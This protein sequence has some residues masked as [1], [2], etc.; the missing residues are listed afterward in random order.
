MRFIHS[1]GAVIVGT[2][3]PNAAAQFQVD[4]VLRGFLPPRMSTAQRD[5]IAS[6]PDG[7]MLY[8]NTTNKLQV[9]AAGAW[10]DLH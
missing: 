6:P 9:R 8:N 4:S 5:A 3:A 1:S 2:G 10:V 7:L